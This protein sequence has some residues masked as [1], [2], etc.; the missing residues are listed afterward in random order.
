VRNSGKR[1]GAEVVELYIH[2]GHASIDRPIQELKGFRRVSLTP[3]ETKVVQFTLDRSALAFF[4]PTKKEWVAEPG[5]FD[6]LVGSSSRDI[7]V[8]GSLTLE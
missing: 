1:A 4:S 3:G 5:Q 7:R 6:V 8:K 2:D